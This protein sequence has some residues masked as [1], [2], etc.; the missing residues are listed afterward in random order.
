MCFG[1]EVEIV[2]VGNGGGGVAVVV[3][4]SGLR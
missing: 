3:Y 1:L 2:S 4:E